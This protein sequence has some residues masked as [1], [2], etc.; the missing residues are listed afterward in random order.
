VQ[1]EVEKLAEKM[2]VR[3]FLSERLGWQLN[4]MLLDCKAFCLLPTFYVHIPAQH[5]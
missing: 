3:Y 4:F 5:Q 2:I 1:Q